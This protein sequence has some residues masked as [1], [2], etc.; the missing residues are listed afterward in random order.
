MEI[1]E[2]VDSGHTEWHVAN[3][4]AVRVTEKPLVLYQ[5]VELGRM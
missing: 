2:R 4:Y 1:G 3:V 5:F